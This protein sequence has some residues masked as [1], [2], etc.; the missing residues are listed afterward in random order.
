MFVPSEPLP[1][2]L[3]ALR[4]SIVDEVDIRAAVAFVT[5]SG[6][7]H[8]A[9]VLDGVHVN[10]LEITARAA[11]VTEPEALKALR[12]QIA[13]DV[14]VVIGKHAREFHP[15]LWM[16]TRSDKVVVISGSG[17]LTYG[18]LVANN[19]QFEIIE[20]ALGDPAIRAHHD[21]LDALTGHAVALDAVENAAIWKEWGAV[22][23]KQALLLI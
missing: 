12:D 4:T 8:L 3:T 1:D 15:K 14:S 11:D 22:R 5:R 20:L 9:S 16:V 10:S 23:K 21:R 2:V 13:A 18:G 6:V 19:E 17:N 7:D